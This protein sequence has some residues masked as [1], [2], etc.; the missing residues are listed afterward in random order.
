MRLNPVGEFFI[1]HLFCSKNA[2]CAHAAVL[3]ARAV[4]IFQRT[5]SV[6]TS[7]A[8]TRN[9]KDPNVEKTCVRNELSDG[10]KWRQ[11]EWRRLFFPVVGRSG[12]VG[13]G[14]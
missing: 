3:G 13:G 7:A 4:L 1:K 9:N 14:I 10:R 11:R 5:V 12:S 6:I 8:G 2:S